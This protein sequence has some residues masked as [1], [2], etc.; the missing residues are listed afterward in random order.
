[1]KNKQKTPI[2]S[3]KTVIGFVYLDAC[4]AMFADAKIIHWCIVAKI[5]VY[6]SFV[7]R[8]AQVT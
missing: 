4:F 3:K 2:V 6:F 5:T 1:M 7:G 8:R